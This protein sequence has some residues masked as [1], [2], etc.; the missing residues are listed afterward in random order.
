MI[1]GGSG[2][3][4]CRSFKK[5]DNWENKGL[6]YVDRSNLRQ[7]LDRVDSFHPIF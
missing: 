5:K 4:G 3:S 6:G 7:N 2:M 1:W